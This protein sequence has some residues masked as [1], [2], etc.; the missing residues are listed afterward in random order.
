LERDDMKRRADLI[1]D[2]HSGSRG[3]PK[4]QR[5]LVKEMRKQ[6]L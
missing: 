2:L 1:D 5:K 3:D 4:A 6:A